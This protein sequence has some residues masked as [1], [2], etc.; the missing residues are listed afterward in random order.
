MLHHMKL[1]DSQLESEGLLH[2]LDPNQGIDIPIQV[3]LSQRAI[4]LSLKMSG[5]NI[6]ATLPLK[7]CRDIDVLKNFILSNSNWILKSIQ[8]QKQHTQ[9]PFIPAPLRSGDKVMLR[10]EWISFV[11][12]PCE[13]DTNIV[14]FDHEP[15]HIHFVF[16]KD[17][18]DHYWEFKRQIVEYTLSQ[19]GARMKEQAQKMGLVYRCLTIRE[20]RTKWGSCNSRKNISVDWRIIHAPLWIQDYLIIHE[21]SHLRQMNHSQKFWDLVQAYCPRFKEAR[22]WLAEHSALLE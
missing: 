12:T 14:R 11:L 21:L 7:R 6:I 17:Q 13:S 16:P 18:S 8:K 9:T 3:R 15:F 20:M 2:L 10:G 1:D 5:K 19:I 22:K 4:R